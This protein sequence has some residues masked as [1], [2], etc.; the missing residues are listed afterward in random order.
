MTEK[1]ILAF[2]HGT[3]GMKSAIV[4][5][6]GRIMDLAFRDT[7]IHFLPNGGAEQDPEEWWQA[8]LSTARTLVRNGSVRPENIEAIG[9]SS[10]FSSTVAVAENGLHLMN[11]LTWM[12][13]RGAP[14][15]RERFGGFPRVSGLNLFKALK[16]IDRTGGAPSPSGKDDIAHVLL[17]KNEYPEIYERTF[18]FLPSKDYLNLRL[19]GQFAASYDSM[20][21]FWLTNIK[22]INHLHYDGGLLSK[23]DIDPDKLPVMR[24][25]TDFLGTVLPPVAD[26]IGIPRQ[27]RV[28][29]GSPDH[30]CACIGSGA[31][32]DFEGHLYV[33]TSSWI[34]C[35]VPFK[36][37]DI[38]HSIASF[39]TA[40]PGRY[41]CINEQ[42]LA[43]GCLAH[44]MDNILFH[45]SAQIPTIVPEEAY[46]ALNAVAAQVPPGSDKLIFT[47]W[48]NGERT[49]VDDTLLRGGFHN[50]SKT[51]TRNHM[52]RAVMEGVAYNT[53]WAL[54]HVEKF[55]GQPLDRLRFVGGGA[56]SKVWCQIMADVLQREILQ[57]TGPV[58]ANARG[59]AFIALVGL[60][61]ISFEDI[62]G[63]VPWDSAYLPNPDNRSGYD[64]LFDA[65]LAIH[66][67]NRKIYH[68]LNRL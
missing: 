36:K 5:S 26:E 17:I 11:S 39:P 41:Q 51:T 42:D 34:E 18:K 3:S 28:V 20:H 1:Y 45:E 12:D 7:P 37:T 30:Q 44:L 33:G 43:G 16:W 64:E 54:R 10:T 14:Y 66:A 59:A 9:I 35:M 31:V 53:R 50:I 40:I 25:S 57:V 2:D 61:E 13:S 27:V 48:L 47:P 63:L 29:L 56:K 38:F 4:D 32:N 60:G 46:E 15:I 58:H 19:T 52:I 23:I 24:P 49:P 62:P 22:D 21:L 68:R 67:A 65:F 8:L 55:V 6:R